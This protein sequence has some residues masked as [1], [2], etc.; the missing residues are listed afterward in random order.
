MKIKIIDPIV[1]NAKSS[2]ILNKESQNNYLKNLLDDKTEID[3]EYIEHGF[4]SVESV[5]HASFNAP[6]VIIKAKKA[7]EEGY[8]GVFINCFD[9]P[10]VYAARENIDIPIYG[11]YLPAIITAASLG[12]KIGIITTDQNGLFTEAKKAKEYGFENRIK[13]IKSVDLQVLELFRKDILLTR[14]IDICTD[15]IKKEKINVFVFGCTGMSYIAEELRV[16]LRQKGY[17]VTVIEP[18]AAGMK[19]LEYIIQLKFTNSLYYRINT[20]T[21]KW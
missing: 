3:F 5:L 8:D 11:G 13:S 17:A 20:D 2:E 14:L 6:E 4:A 10:G 19:Y 1:K 12:E 15:S 9:D 7:Q 18:L 16:N 21:L